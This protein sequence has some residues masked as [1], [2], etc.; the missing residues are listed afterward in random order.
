MH[1]YAHALVGDKL[2]DPTARYFG[3]LSLNPRAHLDPIGTL[4][5][6]VAGFGWGKP[7]PFNPANL[8]NPK[9]DSAL[10]AFAGPASNFLI[11]AI[12]AL[13]FQ[14]FKTNQFIGSVLHL[15]VYLNLVLCFFNLIPVHPL[16]GFKVVYG[17]LPMYLA[18]QWE[19]VKPYGVMIL[20][21][22]ILTRSTGVLISPLV[23]LTGKFLGL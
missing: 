7:V 23:D 2:G 5:M 13:L 10:I 1:E 4:M 14:I 16:D 22:L 8:K 6:L 21:I 15:T 11:A 3:R 19:Q 20:I 18:L 9:R 12:F 17:M